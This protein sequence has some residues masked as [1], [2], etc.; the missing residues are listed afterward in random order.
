[1][2]FALELYFEANKASGGKE[3]LD[4]VTGVERMV[5]I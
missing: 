5:D 1:M 3:L 2:Q 4:V